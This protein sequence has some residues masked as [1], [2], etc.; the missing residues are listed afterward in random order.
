[1][2]G[3]CPVMGHAHFAFGHKKTRHRAIKTPE[4]EEDKESSSVIEEGTETVRLRMAQLLNPVGVP[5]WETQQL[6]WERGWIGVS[7]SDSVGEFL[8]KRITPQWGVGRRSSHKPQLLLPPPPAE[9][10]MTPRVEARR[11]WSN[12]DYSQHKVDVKDMGNA[13]R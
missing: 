3:I 4:K 13:S 7:W 8:A 2:T 6:W 12:W 1:M 10:A 9:T 11:Q 5:T